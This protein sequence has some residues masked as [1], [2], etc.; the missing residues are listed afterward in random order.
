[1]SFAV[2]IPENNVH[3]DLIDF[4][5][6]EIE[7]DLFYDDEDYD[8]EDY[9]DEDIKSKPTDSSNKNIS[10][11]TQ[12]TSSDIFNSSKQ[13]STT[14]YEAWVYDGAKLFA[15]TE[16]KKLLDEA[17]INTEF[18]NMFVFTIENNP[19]GS[20]Q[21]ATDKFCDSL[22][23]EYSQNKECVIFIIDID[24]RIILVYSKGNIVEETLNSSKC[25][26]ITD[27]IYDLAH[28]EKYYDCSSKAIDQI[29]RVLNNLN[30]PQPMKVVSNL[31]LALVVGFVIMYLVAL[32]KSKTSKTS[33]DELLKFAAI[34]FNANNPTDIVTGTTKTYCPRSSGSSG[35]GRSGGFGGGGGHSSGGHRF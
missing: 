34:N 18:C 17:Y 10:D 35:G 2:I 9:D 15:Q 32:G 28:N 3:A 1:M 11:K 27:N 14:G 31:F 30:I 22:R 5:L 16:A 25:D 12:N 20:S 23:N 29:N 33:D 8:D 13:N 6:D 4:V 24:S 26:T 21:S 7:N 19:Y